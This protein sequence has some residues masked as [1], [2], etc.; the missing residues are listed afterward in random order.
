MAKGK[1]KYRNIDDFKSAYIKK[2]GSLRYDWSKAK[3]VDYS[4]KICL[5][6]HKLDDD[7]NEHGEFWMKPKDILSYNRTCKKC[8]REN[9]K[10]SLE[11]YINKSI[12]VNQDKNGEPLYDYHLIEKIENNKTKVPIIC[13]KC[14]KVFYQ[15]F[16]HHTKGIGCPYC[17]GMYKTTEEIIE[18]FKKVQGNRYIYDKVNFINNR[19]KVCIICPIHGEFW[20]TPKNH[21]NGKG[22]PTCKESKLEKKL[23]LLLDKNKIEYDRFYR[24][25]EIFNLLSIDFKLKNSNILIECQGKQH[26]GIGGWGKDEFDIQLERDINKNQIAKNNNFE[27]YYLFD[28][29]EFYNKALKNYPDLYN[30]N[31]TFYKTDDLLKIIKE[32]IF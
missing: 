25:K 7:G 1:I 24:N 26:I 20:Q 28:T 3:W 12:E 8:V 16:N 32:K 6:C 17:N 5:I 29:I 4:T 9:A 10:K 22:C 2:Y 18:L 15:T 21:L 14:N 11:Y 30:E 27:L 19:T 23:S 31:N 13:K